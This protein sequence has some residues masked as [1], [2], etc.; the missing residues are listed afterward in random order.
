MYKCI[1]DDGKFFCMSDKEN[2]P[3]IPCPSENDAQS[4]AVFLNTQI[5]T[6]ENMTDYIAHLEMDLLSISRNIAHIVSKQYGF[7][8]CK[9]FSYFHNEQDGIY[10]LVDKHGEFGPWA[11]LVEADLQ[12]LIEFMN[13]QQFE[14][15]DLQVELDHAR[16]ELNIFKGLPQAHLMHDLTQD[17]FEINNIIGF[18][19]ENDLEPECVE[20]ES[21]SVK[22]ILE[23]LLKVMEGYE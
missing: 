2:E 20:Y 1:E 19:V 10:E 6:V 13:R 9:R 4:L 22:E 3:N 16:E 11:S 5:G 14:K 18:F 8:D 15:E 12:Y 21:E 17:I 7:R 23:R